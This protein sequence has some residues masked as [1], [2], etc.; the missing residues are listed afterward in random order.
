MIF[1][2]YCQES[3]EQVCRMVFSKSFG[4][5]IRSI[6]Y[7]ALL[8]D[9]KPK[10]KLDEIAETLNIPRYFLGK[11]MN[12]LVKKGILT[13]VKGHKGGFSISDKTLSTRLTDVME[14]T[15]DSL[16]YNRCVLHLGTCNADDP[17]PVHRRIEPIRK[18]WNNQLM[19][20]TISDLL[21]KG[22]DDFI[23]SIVTIG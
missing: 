16:Q 9:E 3:N 21:D 14:L 6:L 7:L 1:I 13:S 4:Y 8:H 19:A 2:M 23:K 12:R 10:V 22:R 20:I 15:G 18:Q 17:C 5:A 11:V